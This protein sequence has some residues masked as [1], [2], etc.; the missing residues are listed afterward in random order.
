MFRQRLI[1]TLILVPLVLWI[2]YDA[3]SIGLNVLLVCLTM[4]MGWEWL[5]LIPISTPVSKG[6]FLLV[7]LLLIWPAMYGLMPWVLLDVFFWV[8]VLFAVLTFPRSQVLWGHPVWVGGAGLL[9][10]PLVPAA[11]H[12]LYEQALGKDVIVYLLCLIWA[13]DI[14]AYLV[15]K[16]WGRYKLISAVSP[17]K[18]L[19]GTF[20][21]MGLTLL[22][23]A[24]GCVYFKPDGLLAWF[25]VVVLTAL[26]SVLGDLF[27]SMLKRRCHLKDTGQIFPGHGGVLDRLDSLLA[28]LPVFYCSYHFLV[29]S[30]VL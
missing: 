7:L 16:R 15:G 14:G 11:F 9:L 6:L 20:G 25:I 1:T 5:Q 4:L 19:E 22:I 18:T 17:G 10:L 13:A 29:R 26:S 27:I 8:M 21:G 2:I 24:A 23:G 28:A 30:H 3:P 12:A